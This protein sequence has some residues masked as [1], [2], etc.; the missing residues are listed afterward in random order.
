LGGLLLGGI[1]SCYG[2][3]FLLSVGIVIAI[4]VMLYGLEP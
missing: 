4:F 2:A 1:A 3:P